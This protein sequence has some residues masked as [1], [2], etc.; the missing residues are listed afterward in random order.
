MLIYNPYIL[1]GYFLTGEL[2]AAGP[3]APTSQKWGFLFTPSLSKGAE[4]GTRTHNPLREYGPKPYAYTNSATSALL[5]ASHIGYPN[6]LPQ[7]KPKN[8]V[9][10]LSYV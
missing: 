4:G 1:R 10:Y 3:K 2:P 8:G 5:R 6:I 9:N 7:K